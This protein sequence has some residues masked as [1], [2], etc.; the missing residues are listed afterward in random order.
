M[1]EYNS[2]TEIDRD[3]E[4]LKLQTQIDKEQ[5]KLDYSRTKENIAPGALLK[6]ASRTVKNKAIAVKAAVKVLV[7][8]NL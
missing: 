6:S 1:R 3:L 8:R 5:L 4:I 7:E 2:F